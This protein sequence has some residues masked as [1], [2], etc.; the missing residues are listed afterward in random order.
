M[1]EDR[2]IIFAEYRLSLLA[3]TDRP[4]SA[5]YLRYLSYLHV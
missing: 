1:V 2:P 4:C 5:I 3:N